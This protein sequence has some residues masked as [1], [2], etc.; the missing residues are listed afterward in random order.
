MLNPQW[1][2]KR[3]QLE[4]RSVWISIYLLINS[5]CAFVNFIVQGPSLVWSS[6]LWNS[7]V[8]HSAPTFQPG[9]VLCGKLYS[10]HMDLCRHVATYRDGW[11][12]EQTDSEKLH[13]QLQRGEAPCALWSHTEN[14][15]CHG[16]HLSPA[17]VC[18]AVASLL[19]RFLSLTKISI[20]RA[21]DGDFSLLWCCLV[22]IRKKQL[23]VWG[24]GKV[25]DWYSFKENI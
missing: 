10:E 1:V 21:A 14:K 4:K 19:E 9:T 23:C 22:N 17:C 12:C 11:I 7:N 25:E 15:T 2:I 24:R 20:I 16:Q 18:L 8:F 6:L 3:P 5:E 13:T